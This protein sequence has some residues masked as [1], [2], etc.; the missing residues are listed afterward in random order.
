MQDVLAK[1]HKSSTGYKSQKV[2]DMK[3]TPGLS[4]RIEISE[5]NSEHISKSSAK[6]PGSNESNNQVE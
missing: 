1:A 5:H 4:N 6:K 3:L 2:A